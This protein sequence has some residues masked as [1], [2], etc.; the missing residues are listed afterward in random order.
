MSLASARSGLLHGTDDPAALAAVEALQDSLLVYGLDAG[1]LVAPLSADPD[2]AAG[3]AMAAALHLCT[4][5]AEGQAA[6][7]PLVAAARAAAPRA[8]RREK[9]FVAAID[10]WHCGNI[11]RALAAH[12][13]IAEAF[14]RDLVSARFAQFHLVNRGDWRRLLQLTQ[15]VRAANP[16]VPQADGMH[17]FALEQAG[18]TEAAEALG[19]AAADRAFDP[20]AEHAVAH[21]LDRQ[22]RAAD[23]IAFLAPRSAGWQRCSSFLRGH[24]W[25]H[26]ALFHLARAEPE[27]AL[28]LFDREIWGLRPD[29]AQD[30]VNAV[31]LLARLELAGHPVGARW[32]A[33]APFLARGAAHGANG[34]VDLVRALGLGRA[35]PV[36]AARL[37][38]RLEREAP[39][40]RSH[41]ARTLLPAAAAGLAAYGRGDLAATIRGLGPALPGL[42]AAGGSATQQAVLAGVL[43]D[44][45]GASAPVATAAPPAAVPHQGMPVLEPAPALSRFEFWP[46]RLFY[47]PIWAWAGLLS[48]RHGG[49]RLP[50]IANPGLPAG[51][52]VGESK[53][54]ILDSVGAPARRWFAAHV[55]VARG[56]GPADRA[57]AHALSRAAAAGLG[58]PLV[59]KPDLGCRGAGVR[60]VRS[61]AELEAYLAAFPK[62]ATLVLQRLVP[63]EAEA[64]IAW[65][66]L[67]GAARGRIVSITLKYFPHVVGDGR[68][69]VEQ[70]IHA[71]P[72]AGRLAHLYLGRNRDQLDRVPAAGEAVRLAFAGSHSRGAIFRDGTALATPALEA[73]LEEIC[74][75][76]PE[77]WFGRFD[78]RFRDIA[79]L[80][81]GEDFQILEVNG[82]GA[83]FTHIWDSRMTLARAYRSLCAQ[84][85]LAF[86]IGAMNRARGFR[87]EPLGQTLAR[88]RRERA[89]VR[90]YPETA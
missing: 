20:W 24:N 84:W 25:W 69:T 16:D 18:E 81:R 38:A 22:G 43:A 74:A 41:L 27:A 70:L 52:L 28:A 39:A 31:L 61:A 71:D 7:A 49:L 1:A 32:Q 62:G 67:P 14:P 12:L 77:F 29:H 13:A 30:Q 86:R 23:G 45:M 19:R 2:F 90:A 40:A 21:A 15:R 68:A 42:H 53:S 55:A 73:R 10:A 46:A 79:A 78:V 64:G 75:H 9:L 3:Q 50:L 83:E 59:A 33:V 60:P 5:S 47:L 72:R 65:V 35:D 57:L 51:G 56:H 26:L 58:F 87:P 8:Q 34:F 89:L 88:L 66:K 82:A 85:G 11:P 4:L 44:A 17:A 76:I 63:W 6:A 54:A 48:L 37:V 80:Q 36:A